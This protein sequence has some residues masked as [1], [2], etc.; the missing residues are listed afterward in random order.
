MKSSY[1]KSTDCQ[2]CTKVYKT[3]EGKRFRCDCTCHLK[4]VKKVVREIEDED[5]GD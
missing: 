3:A 4:E 2:Y 1:C 5:Y